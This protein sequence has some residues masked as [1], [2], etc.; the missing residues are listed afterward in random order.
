MRSNR[1]SA[2]RRSPLTVHAAAPENAHEGHGDNIVINQ[3]STN[4]PNRIALRVSAFVRQHDPI[5]RFVFGKMG[6]E[7]MPNAPRWMVMLY[8]DV[9]TAIARQCYDE[10]IVT[11]IRDLPTYDVVVGSVLFSLAGDLNSIIGEYQHP[12][13]TRREDRQRAE[14]DYAKYESE[15]KEEW[16]PERTAYVGRRIAFMQA[17]VSIMGALQ[18]SNAEMNYYSILGTLFDTVDGYIPAPVLNDIYLR[19][20]AGLSERDSMIRWFYTSLTHHEPLTQNLINAELGGWRE[21][22]MT[23]IADEY[24]PIINLYVGVTQ[25]Q[26]DN[27][28]DPNEATDFAEAAQKIRRRHE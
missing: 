3:F 13:M 22:G 8:D 6:R 20:T 24:A 2:Q 10:G 27:G 21:R 15:Q 5:R 25:S 16:T 28:Y 18:D 26:L 11:T 12:V 14:A 23:D 17:W 7:L 4:N 9:I 1:I 19:A